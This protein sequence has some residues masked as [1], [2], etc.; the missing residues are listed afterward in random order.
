MWML[1][2]NHIE[3][4]PITVTQKDK[5]MLTYNIHEAIDLRGKT[6]R[7]A[8]LADP[9]CCHPKHWDEVITFKQ[10]IEMS[11]GNGGYP[12]PPLWVEVVGNPPNVRQKVNKGNWKSLYSN[13][14]KWIRQ[15]YTES[16]GHHPTAQE[17][18]QAVIR[19]MRKSDP[20]DCY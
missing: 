19:D 1:K 9:E 7:E 3:L 14:R 20:E 18:K 13:Y 5:T 2:E 8:G 10:S 17:I 6:I 4:N 16:G 12:E 15:C 11:T